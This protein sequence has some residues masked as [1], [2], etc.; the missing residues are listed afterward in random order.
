MGAADDPPELSRVRSSDFLGWVGGF[1]EVEFGEGFRG[2][3]AGMEK[4]TTE[5]AGRLEGPGLRRR[6]AHDTAGFGAG[7]GADVEA[8]ALVGLGAAAGSAS[9]GIGTTVDVEGSTS[10]TAEGSTS[11]RESAAADVEGSTSDSDNFGASM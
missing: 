11:D 3:D 9:D 6:E 4:P 1:V 5:D 8:S 7:M 10:D 2:G